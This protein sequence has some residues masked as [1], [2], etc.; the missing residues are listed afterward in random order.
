MGRVRGGRHH[1]IFCPL[2][3][4]DCK[5]L[6]KSSDKANE[7]QG[8][9]CTV[10]ERTFGEYQEV[11]HIP[12]GSHLLTSILVMLI[13]SLASSCTLGSTRSSVEF[14][15]YGTTR[16]SRCLGKSEYAL[17]VFIH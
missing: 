6:E 4:G 10:D 1:D 5:F 16:S 9:A 3:Y 7:E 8:Q 11:L 2:E 12:L 14:Y 17:C 13:P 15:P